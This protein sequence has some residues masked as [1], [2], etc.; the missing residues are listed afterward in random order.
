MPK[1]ARSENSSLILCFDVETTGLPPRGSRPSIANAT[2]WPYIVQLSWVIYDEGAN[3]IL[4]VQDMI[5][6]PGV[7]VPIASS[8]I[9]GISD[10]RA[11]TEG[12]LIQEALQLFAGECLRCQTVVSHNLDFDTNMIMIESIRLKLQYPLDNIPNKVCT[13]KSSVDICKIERT[14]RKGKVYYKFPKLVELHRHYFGE[15][16]LNLHDALVDCS[17]CLR[18]YVYAEYGRDV[19]N[20][21]KLKS[22]LHPGDRIVTQVQ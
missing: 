19:F 3:S 12:V 4:S 15:T 17:I 14:N 8:A 20:I 10:R 7:E 6:N 5:V 13:M 18:C 9:H 16:D 21:K 22:S 11:K 1:Q 2:S